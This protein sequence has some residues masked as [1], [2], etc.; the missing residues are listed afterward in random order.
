MILSGMDS[1]SGLTQFIQKPTVAYKYTHEFIISNLK[2][3]EIIAYRNHLWAYKHEHIFMIFNSKY[4][5]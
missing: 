1:Y 4:K 3:Q 2:F 5:A